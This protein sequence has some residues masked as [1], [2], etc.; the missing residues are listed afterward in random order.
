M[1]AQA[2]SLAVEDGPAEAPIAAVPATPS[3]S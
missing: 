3:S 1:N 2:A